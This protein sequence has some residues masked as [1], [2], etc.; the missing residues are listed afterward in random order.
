MKVLNCFLSQE[1][2]EII[3][4]GQGMV[5]YNADVPSDLRGMTGVEEEAV[6]NFENIYSL[7]LNE[8]GGRDASLYQ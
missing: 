4:A 7:S 3:A 2:Q 8:K 1:G 6:A 5:S